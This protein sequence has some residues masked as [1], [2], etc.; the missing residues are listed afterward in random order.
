VEQRRLPRVL[1]EPLLAAG[2]LYADAR[3]KDVE[4]NNSSEL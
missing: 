1:L 2:T 3:A 4:T